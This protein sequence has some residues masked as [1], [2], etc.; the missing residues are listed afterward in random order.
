M[1]AFNVWLNG[2]LIDTVFY[3]SMD[4]MKIA[5]KVVDVKKSLINHDGY[6]PA[7]IVTWPKGQRVTRDEWELQGNYGYGH[8]WECLCAGTYAEV[9][10]NKKD[11]R[12]NEPGTPTRIVCKRVKI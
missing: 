4:G 6:D 11:Y 3:G 12:E 8:G 5:D 9:K 7:I 10:A 2:K 1:L